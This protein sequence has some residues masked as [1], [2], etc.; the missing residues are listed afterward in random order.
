MHSWKMD[1]QSHLV[2]RERTFKCIENEAAVEFSLLQ[3]VC[4]CG[5]GGGGGGGGGLEGGG[6]VMFKSL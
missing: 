4:V 6:V 1:Q 5:G 3:C 2:C